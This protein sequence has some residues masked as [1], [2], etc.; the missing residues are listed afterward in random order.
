MASVVP[1]RTSAPFADEG[2]C[3]ATRMKQPKVIDLFAGAGGFSCGF[4]AAGAEVSFAL[5]KDAWAAETFAFNHPTA[6]MALRDIE[7][8][9]DDEIKKLI[10]PAPEILIGGPPCQGFS[11]SN[12]AN[13]DPRDP[14]N[15]LFIEF[16]RFVRRLRPS[17]CLL[18]NVPGLLTSRTHQGAA[19]IDIIKDS[20]EDAGYD[21]D[22]RIL[23]ADRYGVPQ[24]RQRLFIIG[25]RKGS[26]IKFHWPEPTHAEPAAARGSNL[27]L[28]LAPHP[29]SLHVTLW[30]AISDL[31]QITSE[32]HQPDLSYVS[33]PQNAYQRVMREGASGP[34][35]NHEPMRHTR[36]VV[37]RF[38]LIPL[39]GGEAQVPAHF[40]PRKRSQPEKISGRVYDQ[41]SRRQ[42]PDRPCN[43]IPASSHTNFLHPFLNRNFTVRELMRIQSFPDRFIAKGKRAVL[44]H[45]L[46]R[47]KGLNDEVNLDQRMQIG[48]AVPPLL[49]RAVAEEVL[50][51]LTR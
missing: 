48:N 15:S 34:I 17:I 10:G 30:E 16:L 20:F 43:T 32:L 26:G 2:F 28:F 38:G 45:K 47:R 44:S 7:S 23:D 31:P 50:A 37:A 3:S 36:R 41:N 39:G 51:S 8:V 42:F 5:E 4:Q 40:S 18:E 13:R 12:I 1:V 22:A 25:I 46:S 14:R 27:D 6:G 19:V 9:A 29:L 21:A 11:H 33:D 24:F 35:A 49:A